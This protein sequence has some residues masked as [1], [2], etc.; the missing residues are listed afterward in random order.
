MIGVIAATNFSHGR[1]PF[2]GLG[3]SASVALGAFLTVTAL[4]GLLVVGLEAKR[5]LDVGSLRERRLLVVPLAAALTGMAPQTVAK[6]AAELA[7]RDD[8]PSGRGRRPGGLR[9]GEG[10]PVR[11]PQLVADRIDDAIG[12]PARSARIIRVCSGW[13]A[14]MR[15]KNSR[16]R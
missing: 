15:R 7:S 1:G 13:V 16:F 11:P 2:T 5:E 6:G 14:P 10:G 4:T 3:M 9:G 8:P 12:A